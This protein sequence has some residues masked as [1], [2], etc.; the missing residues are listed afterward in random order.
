MERGTSEWLMRLIEPAADEYESSRTK[1][2][3]E[4]YIAMRVWAALF[5]HDPQDDSW[6]HQ[7]T[8]GAWV[9]MVA[10]NM[11]AWRRVTA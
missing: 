6:G 11:Y 10:R 4:H 2:S 3:P 9:R 1:L 7:G 5:A 8:M